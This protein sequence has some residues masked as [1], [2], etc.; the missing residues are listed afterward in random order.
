MK[1]QT[2]I[3]NV[4]FP[5]WIIWLFPQALVFIL[6]GN[7]AID[8]AV[9]LVALLALKHAQKGAAIGQLW[10]KFWLLEIGRASCRERV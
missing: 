2:R 9:L 4:L 8:C 10:W 3:Y 6:P 1:K 7:L 5:I